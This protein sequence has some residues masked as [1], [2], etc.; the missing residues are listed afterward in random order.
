MSSCSTQG[1]E[2]DYGTTTCDCTPGFMMGGDEWRCRAAPSACP[3]TE[4]AAGSMCTAGTGDP[5]GCT[6]PG[7]T[8]LCRMVGGMF[9]WL[10][11]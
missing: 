2:C 3:P 1:L 8:C 4:P 11:S 5:G 7:G 6:Y 9:E 10:C